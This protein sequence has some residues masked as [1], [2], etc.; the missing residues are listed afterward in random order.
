MQTISKTVLSTVAVLLV[1]AYLSTWS[2]ALI[3]SLM[4]TALGSGPASI[5]TSQ[6]SPNK[7]PQITFTQRRHTPLV[8]S[9]SLVAPPPSSVE[10]PR[11]LHLMLGIVEPYKTSLPSDPSLSPLFGRSPPLC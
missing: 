5:S 7:K 3:H 6:D 1:G 9:I 8:K 2:A 4:V 10:Y 11:V